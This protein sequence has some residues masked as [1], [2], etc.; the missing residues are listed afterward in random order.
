MLPQTKKIKNALK[1]AGILYK[2]KVQHADTK[3]SYYVD[4]NTG[5]RKSY[6]EHMGSAFVVTLATCDQIDIVKSERCSARI[7]SSNYNAT[8]Q[9]LTLIQSQEITP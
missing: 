6:V 4:A 1:A 9:H 7:L 2:T 8:D 5:T 3:R